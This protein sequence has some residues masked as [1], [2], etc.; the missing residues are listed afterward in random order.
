MTTPATLPRA[1]TWLNL[2]R[3][4]GARNDNLFKL[5]II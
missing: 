3:L 5:L 2:P 1:F 4:F